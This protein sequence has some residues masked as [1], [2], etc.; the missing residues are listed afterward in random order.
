MVRSSK[1]DSRPS[2]V[3]DDQVHL[4]VDQPVADVRASLVDLV[5]DLDVEAV[6][7]QIGGRALRRHQLEAEPGEIAGY[8]HDVPLVVV[9]DADEGSSPVRQ[10]LA[11]RELGLGERDPEVLAAPHHL[12]GRLHLRPQKGVDAGEADEREDR[13][14]TKTPE[15]SRSAVNPSS[16]RVLPTI[17]RAATFASGTPVAFER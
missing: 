7:A 13:S 6:G 9:V 16:A 14:L 2:G 8:R 3:L 1:Y 4:P 10:P 17:N 11:G 5:D 15:T 12:P